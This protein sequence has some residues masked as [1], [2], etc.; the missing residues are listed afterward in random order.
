MLYSYRGLITVVPT[1]EKREV[2]GIIDVSRHHWMPEQR[3]RDYILQAEN[4]EYDNLTN[5]TIKAVPQI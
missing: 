3:I 4:V 1:T 2:K 5:F